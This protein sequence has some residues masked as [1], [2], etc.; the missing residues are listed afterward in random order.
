LMNQGCKGLFS[1]DVISAFNI[2]SISAMSLFSGP[3]SLLYNSLAFLSACSVADHSNP[4][5]PS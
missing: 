4:C 2:L 3:D 1:K 5:L